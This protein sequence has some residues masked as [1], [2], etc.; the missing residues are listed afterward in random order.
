MVYEEYL[1]PPSLAAVVASFWRFELEPHDP[2]A[3]EHAIP[4]DGCV[5]IAV[6]FSSRGPH[7]I[8][9]VGPRLSALRVPVQ[10]GVQ[11][12]G[13][14]T[15]PG[16]CTSLLGVSPRALRGQAVALSAVAPSKAQALTDA[17]QGATRAGAMLEALVQVTATWV[18]TGNLPDAAVMAMVRRILE[19][20]GQEPVGA[21]AAGTGLSYRQGLRRFVDAV[22]LSP[23]ELSR[24]TRLRHA[25]LE[26]LAGDGPAW[27]DVAASS[28]FADQA[29]MT[30][31]FSEVFGW[32][33]RLV[34]E[35]LRRIEHIHV[36]GS[37]RRAK[38]DAD[39]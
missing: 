13:V 20:R 21:I 6:A 31:E 19:A 32:P 37:S 27:A 24:L 22:G 25:C 23:K 36:A 12:A 39:R 7:H 33:P 18:A 9:L 4:P 38:T 28:G 16:G 10:R 15:W 3:L 14:R 30:R 2:D 1:P 29:H 11:Y 8:A 5:S 26:A 17:A 35:Y 34:R